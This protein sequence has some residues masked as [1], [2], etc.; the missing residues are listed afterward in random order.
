MLPVFGVSLQEAVVRSRCHDGVD[1]PLPVRE[2]IDYLEIHGKT[3]ENIY[4][5]NGIKSKV[6]HIKKL[7]NQR[8]PVN[9]EDYDVPTVTSV[10][11]M[12]FR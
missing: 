5:V 4:K 11:K 8:E 12:F 3:F 7:Y 6:L 1:L 2:C 10:F 9:L